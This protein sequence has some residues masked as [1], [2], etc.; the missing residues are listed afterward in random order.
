M[1]C[2]SVIQKSSKSH[3]FGGM[4]LCFQLHTFLKN[5][6]FQILPNNTDRIEISETYKQPDEMLCCYRCNSLAL[7]D[8]ISLLIFCQVR[9][10]CNSNWARYVAQFVR[11]KVLHEILR[12]SQCHAWMPM[13]YCINP[14]HYNL[15]LV[16]YNI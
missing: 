2:S 9:L 11:L 7:V 15:K 8:S 3:L 12:K 13:H 1:F 10:V 5:V 14:K 4:V 6:S 16:F